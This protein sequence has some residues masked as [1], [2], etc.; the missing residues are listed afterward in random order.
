M[1]FRAGEVVELARGESFG[2]AG[3]AARG[4]RGVVLREPGLMSK[5]YVVRLDPTGRQV[6]LP[7][8]ALRPSGEL[9]SA[10][11]VAQR[12]QEAP[13]WQPRSSATSPGRPEDPKRDRTRRSTPPPAPAPSRA[14]PV[15]AATTW[16]GAGEVGRRAPQHSA[17]PDSPRRSP[18]DA[19][20]EL[21]RRLGRR[22]GSGPGDSG[23]RP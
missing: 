20:A 6:E 12:A 18:A 13:W 21:K 17:R 1:V 19:V 16:R 8:E 11:P 9:W 15:R 5:G 2:L 10:A 7:A 23:R 14:G 3:T 22:R 4:T